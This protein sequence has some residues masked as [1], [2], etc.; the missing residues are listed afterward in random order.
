MNHACPAMPSV[1]LPP[2]S[3]YPSDPRALERERLYAD[4]ERQE[5]TPAPAD[6]FG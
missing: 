2:T 4:F 5:D 3:A 6:V 1:A